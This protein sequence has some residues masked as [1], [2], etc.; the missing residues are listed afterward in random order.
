MWYQYLMCIISGFIMGYS[1]AISYILLKSSHG[2]LRISNENPE[3]KLYSFEIDD[4]EA[5]EHT[6]RIILKITRK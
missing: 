5:L 6:N 4:L 2:I 1:V 3:K